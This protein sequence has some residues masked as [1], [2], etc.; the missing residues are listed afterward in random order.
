MPPIDINDSSVARAQ[1][2]IEVNIVFV[3]RVKEKI[4]DIRVMDVE[5]HPES[6]GIILWDHYLQNLPTLAH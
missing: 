5:Q 4:I 3:N 2:A 6:V 1:A